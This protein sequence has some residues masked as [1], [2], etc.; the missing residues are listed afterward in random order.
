[1]NN[2]SVENLAKNYDERQLFENLTFGL[3]QGQK[4]ALV[5][6]NGCGKSTLLKIIAGIEP[7]DRG[8]VS[9][10]KGVRVAMVPQSPEFDDNDNIVQ[11]VFAEDIE[12][13]NV[14]R[15][16]EIAI[17]KA[18]VDPENA[19]DLTDV[20]ERMD[21]LNAW[22]Y[23]SQVKQLLGELGLHDLEQKMGELSGGQ[24]KRVALARALVVKPDFLILD[25]PTNHLDLDV[26]EW[27]ESYLATANLTLLMVTH[28]RYFLD[29][30]T[31]EIMEIDQGELFRYKGN[32]QNFLE[33]KAE[34]EAQDA[35]TVDKA[36]NLLR[37]E[38]EW[39][40]RQPKARGTKAKYR[41]D[42]FY[43]TKE[44]A[45]KG[46]Q[47]AEM[48]VN[49]KGERQ[50][51]KILVMEHV[52]KRFDKIKILENFEHT[53]QRKER[54]GIVGPNGVGKST[55]LNLLIGNILPD[56][57]N[58]ELGQTTKFGY[59][60]Q[61]E[62]IFNPNSRVIDV[63]KEVAEVIKMADGSVITASQL[64][65]Q[66]LFPPKMQFN[67]V[68]K[69]SGGERRRLQLLRVL[70][71]NPNFLILDEP[72]NDLDLMTL[73]VL[74]DYLDNF[75][76]CLMIVSHDRYFMD[77]LTDHL[78]IF[79]GE[80][81]VRDFPGNYTDFREQ[82]GK[83]AKKEEAPKKSTDK[84]PAPAEPVKTEK[85]KLS[86]NEQ[87][88]YDKL[89]GEIAKLEKERDAKTALMN[90]KTDFEELQKLAEELEAIRDSIEEKEMRWLELSDKAGV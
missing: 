70:M 58:M 38:L 75:E 15:D 62:Q 22:D 4:A 3:E 12:E 48:E 63:I 11:A 78:F 20:L 10:R 46:I 13:L 57:G 14:I 66:F 67:M 85:K 34:R 37:K 47:R 24:R 27:L 17:H 33:K 88:E 60:T 8:E 83:L 35:A 71:N 64:L 89:E 39:M 72:T 54:V 86:Y 2:L 5:G 53:F 25:E 51:K 32:Y 41:V 7:P 52:S 65:N 69:L 50:G 31:N 18:T 79:E 61:E 77:K 21:Q 19:P 73:N 29:R 87:R 28:D 30:V 40:R 74:E 45:S 44:K 23:E 68:G 1:M 90:Q 81:Q 16:Y 82:G 36:K 49:L 42:A 26:I 6:V 55:F 56:S 43:E 76:G 59:Y 9:F 80:G 84:S